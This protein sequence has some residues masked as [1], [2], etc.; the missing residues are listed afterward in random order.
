MSA[1]PIGD[2][3][4][5]V[6]NTD[7]YIASGQYVNIVL[8]NVPRS[9]MSLVSQQSPFLL[10]SMLQHEN[11]VSVLHFNIQRCPGYDGIVRSKDSL[12]FMSGSRTF[13]ANPIF[14]EA[15]LNCDKHKFERYVC[16]AL[17]K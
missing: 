16:L 4:L 13:R 9:A 10:F 7:S 2:H 11:K 5:L 15:N 1:E 12:V 3:P 17:F 14:S 8:R 6:P